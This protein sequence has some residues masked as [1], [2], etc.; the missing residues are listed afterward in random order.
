ME[1]LIPHNYFENW[2]AQEIVVNQ[3]IYVDRWSLVHFSAG[4][5]LAHLLFKCFGTRA[6]YAMILPILTMHEVVEFFFGG[7]V[8]DPEPKLDVM[9]DLIIGST[10][11]T[12][13]ALLTFCFLPMYRASKKPTE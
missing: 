6:A 10:G 11:F 2:L 4:F 9:W 8:F 13:Y 7:I 5:V 1:R 12:L 3:A